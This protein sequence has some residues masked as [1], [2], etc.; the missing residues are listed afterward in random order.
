MKKTGKKVIGGA[1]AIG[2]GYNTT[3]SVKANNAKKSKA[4]AAAKAKRDA[5]A[6]KVRSSTSKTAAK[7]PA[8]K[9]AKKALPAYARLGKKATPKRYAMVRT[10]SSRTGINKGKTKVE[11]GSSIIRNKNGTIKKVKPPTKK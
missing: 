4:A 2:A 5:A 8:K 7:T 10:D 11:V 9:A 1:A 3:K 6:S